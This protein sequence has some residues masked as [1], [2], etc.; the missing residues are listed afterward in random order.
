MGFCWFSDI[1]WVFLILVKKNEVMDAVEFSYPAGVT[2]SKLMGSEGC[3]GGGSK[4]DPSSR[5]F[6]DKKGSPFDLILFWIVDLMFLWCLL[7]LEINE[8]IV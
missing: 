7:M 4:M 6:P 2:V 1:G 8:T 3:G 5:S